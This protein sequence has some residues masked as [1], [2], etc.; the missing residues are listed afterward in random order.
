[1]S[2]LSFIRNWIVGAKA[3]A[4]MAALSV[5]LCGFLAA[6]MLVIVAI[7]SAPKWLLGTVFGVFIIVF[8]PWSIGQAYG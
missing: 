5:A 6:V 7:I 2:I 1:M 8:G 3:M 4:I